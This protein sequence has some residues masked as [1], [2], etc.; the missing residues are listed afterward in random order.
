MNLS[1]KTKKNEYKNKTF[2]GIGNR[3][4]VAKEEEE[5]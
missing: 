2:T 3:L 1:T 5:I 4:V